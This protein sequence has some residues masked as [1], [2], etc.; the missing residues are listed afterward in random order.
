MRSEDTQDEPVKIVYEAPAIEERVNIT[1]GLICVG[2]DCP[3]V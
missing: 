2:S 3:G 1:A